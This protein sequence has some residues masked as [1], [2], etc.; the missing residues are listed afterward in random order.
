MKII[1]DTKQ[2]LLTL[3]DIRFH[4]VYLFVTLLRYPALVYASAFI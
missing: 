1:L 3:I 4:F 2:N